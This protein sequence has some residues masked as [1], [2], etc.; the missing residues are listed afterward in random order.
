MIFKCFLLF[1]T[2]RAH[3]NACASMRWLVEIHSRYCI[4]GIILCFPNSHGA[5]YRGVMKTSGLRRRPSTSD[6]DRRPVTFTELFYWWTSTILMFSTGRCR[7]LSYSTGRRPFG[8]MF[9]SCP[10]TG[11][12]FLAIILSSIVKLQFGTQDLV[13]RPGAFVLRLKNSFFK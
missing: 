7:P 1:S 11:I 12:I 2:M 3:A 10:N 13:L 4:M 5:Q 8:L 9:S 6:V